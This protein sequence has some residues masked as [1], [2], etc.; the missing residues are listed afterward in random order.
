MAERFLIDGPTGAGKTT[1]LNILAEQ[2]RKIY[3]IIS[4]ATD[5]NEFLVNTVKC[6]QQEILNLFGKIPNGHIREFL[7]ESLFSVPDPILRAEFL[8]VVRDFIPEY[9]DLKESK[10][11]NKLSHIADFPGILSANE[12]F[13]K[14]AKKRFFVGCEEIIRIQ[15][16]IKRGDPMKDIP[17]NSSDVSREAHKLPPPTNVDEY[18]DNTKGID[19]LEEQIIRICNGLS[20]LQEIFV[21][22]SKCGEDNMQQKM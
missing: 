9:M 14:N 22:L 20:S 17:Q 12:D 18:I 19:Y 15:R 8:G 16:K 7:R 6:K 21:P 11:S 4:L 13:V 2:I 3:G 5:S 1:T 10:N